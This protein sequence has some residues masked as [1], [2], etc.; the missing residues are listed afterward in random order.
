MELL[1][2]IPLISLLILVVV[3][4]ELSKEEDLCLDK[5]MMYHKE[6]QHC[7]TLLSPKPCASGEWFVLSP[8]KSS[9]GAPVA[10]CRK[11]GN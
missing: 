3:G 1:S 7:Y 9:P 4:R 6:S 11:V 8:E 10:E 5:N 2:I